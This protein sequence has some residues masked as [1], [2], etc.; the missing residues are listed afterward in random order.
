M[1]K[2]FING[3]PALKTKV[4]SFGQ[5]GNRIADVFASFKTGAGERSYEC[6]ALNSNT[7]DLKELKNI[8]DDN[9]MSL[10]LG[11]LGKNPVKAMKVLEENK[12]VR[13][14]M[15]EFVTSKMTDDDDLALFVVGLG[16][17]TGTST[18]IKAL[19]NFHKVY[20]LPKVQDALLEIVQSIDGGVI[21]YKANPSKYNKM[22]LKLAQERFVKIGVIAVLPVRNDGPDVLRQTNEF[23]QKLWK[24]GNDE[25]K[26]ISFTH[27]PD[28]QLFSDA[29]KKLPTDQRDRFETYR[30]YANCEIA[31]TF[32]EINTLA[33]MGGTSVVLDKADLKRAL[34]EG[35][36]CLSISRV[37]ELINKD[38]SNSSVSK[39]FTK[40]LKSGN[41]HDAIELKKDDV[42]KR[43]H[44]VCLLAA[45]DSRSKLG[46]SGAFLDDAIEK[47][48]GELPV[49]G[50][51]FSGFVECQNNQNA[52][53]YLVFKS[54]GLPPRLQMGLGEEYEEHMKKLNEVKFDED[55][56]IKSIKVETD[57]DDEEF[58]LADLGLGDLFGEI[59]IEEPPIQ[60]KKE[61]ISS[62]DL[63]ELMKSELAKLK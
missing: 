5:A 17:G 38:S 13:E 43:V 37:S 28:N 29:F 40:A 30:N 21:E 62:D 59:V 26:G 56:E 8:S 45:I 44:H 48:N 31:E 1:V 16:G 19:E 52:T 39:L 20:N 58:S 2:S 23:A 47:L 53:A 54:N 55:A 33:D 60:E 24:L 32:H 12:D 4:F 41:L 3:T 36:G 46:G 27:F 18:V 6:Y 10:E 34:T 25:T 14:K 57:K 15:E 61:T 22:A 51:V 35:Q 50:T 11:G 63:R 9:Q 42:I 7:G 49:T